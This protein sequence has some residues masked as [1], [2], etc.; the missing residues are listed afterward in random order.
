MTTQEFVNKF[1]S[2]FLWLNLAGMAGVVLLVVL[3][4]SLGTALYTHHGEAIEVPDLVGHNIT[5]AEIVC[6]GMDIT[7][8]VQDSSYRPQ[9]PEGYIIDQSIKAGS[10]I[11]G[12]RTLYVT[13]NTH[14]APTLLVPDIVGNSST[15]EALALLKTK[16]FKVGEPE[17]VQ[18][19][20]DWVVG[21]RTGNRQLRYGDKVTV[22]DLVIL[23]VGDGTTED[24][25]IYGTEGEYGT[26]TEESEIYER[27]DAG[28]IDDFEV[29]Q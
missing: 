2:R 25:D 7:I 5:D 21:L 15:R 27:G 9:L 14:Q 28:D 4:A 16:G 10:K 6:D 24:L 13:I 17:K 20:R 23:Q 26:D 19:E 12:G 22:N 18:G 1:K 3:L 29:V 11:K 8:E